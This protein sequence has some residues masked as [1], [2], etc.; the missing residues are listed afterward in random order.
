L[1]ITVDE[2]LYYRAINK[3][4]TSHARRDQTHGLDDVALPLPDDQSGS[5]PKPPTE[6]EKL[7]QPPFLFRNGQGLLNMTRENNVRFVLKFR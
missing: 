5:A 4:K 6:G 7:K 2:N 1:L 3:D